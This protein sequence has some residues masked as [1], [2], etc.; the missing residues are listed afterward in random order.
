MPGWQ[1]IP[2]VFQNGLSLILLI[3]MVNA[4]ITAKGTD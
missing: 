3:T 1:I 2:I 4:D